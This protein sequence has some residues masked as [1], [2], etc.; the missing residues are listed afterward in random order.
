M[1]SIS[2]IHGVRVLTAEPET[3]TL[4]SEDDAVELIGQA[5]GEYA[6]VVAVP[7]A[8]VDERFFMLSTRVA[9]EVVRKFQSYRVVLAVLGDLGAYL[10][11]DSF[12]AFVH[13]TN[14]GTD[15][16]FL[17]GRAALHERLRAAA[18]TLGRSQ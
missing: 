17:D 9:G 2:E 10:T 15:V 16:W 11:S 5:Y 13:E 4:G 12:Q 1:H 6:S 14:K 7:V 8:R 3:P 18:E